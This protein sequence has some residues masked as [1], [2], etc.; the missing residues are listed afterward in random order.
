[1]K[2]AK[3]IESFAHIAALIVGA[4]S[5]IALFFKD[6][7]IV[8][9]ACVQFWIGLEQYLSSMISCLVKS[10]RWKEKVIH[11][12]L[13]TIYLLVLFVGLGVI[14]ITGASSVFPLANI[15]T[16]AYVFVLPWALAIYYAII[17]WKETFASKHN[18][19]HFL[20]HTSF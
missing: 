18:N 12:K 11:L 14:K 1:M 16:F 9:L 4:A 6:D 19:S 17:T 3:I 13:A 15:L 10:S 5:A 8:V 20:P 7:F 2:I